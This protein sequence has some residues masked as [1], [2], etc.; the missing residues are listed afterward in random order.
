MYIFSIEYEALYRLYG[1]SVT[2]HSTIVTEYNT[3]DK[4]Y[5]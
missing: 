3:I 2:Q 4:Y 5:T 1:G